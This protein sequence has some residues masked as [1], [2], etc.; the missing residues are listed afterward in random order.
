ML[1][2]FFI[3]FFHMV[4]DAIIYPF[5]GMRNFFKSLLI[6][7]VF[8]YIMTS[9]FVIVDYLT[10]QYGYLGKFMCS[11]GIKDQMQRSVVRVVGGYSEGTG[12]FIAPDQV[13]TNFHVIA[14]EPSPKIIFPDGEFV[15]PCKIVGD[16][17]VDLA[18]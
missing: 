7:L 14:D 8:L 17:E 6:I 10:N 3:S 1:L 9:L 18:I 12:F 16:K 15:T 11:Y 13:L 4:I 5:R 2:R